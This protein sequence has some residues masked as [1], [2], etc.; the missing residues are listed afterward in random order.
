MIPRFQATEPNSSSLA[1]IT[2]PGRVPAGLLE[3]SQ[4]EYGQLESC[5]RP[6]KQAFEAAGRDIVKKGL[7]RAASALGLDDD[8]VKLLPAKLSAHSGELCRLDFILS[9]GEPVVVEANFGTA[10]GGS[11]DVQEL[12]RAHLGERAPAPNRARIQWACALV[13]AEGA[14][15]LYLPHWPWSHVLDPEGYFAESRACAAD[16]GVD[17]VVLSFGQLERE[18]RASTSPIHVLK[19]FATL[20]AV[21][22]GIDLRSLSYQDGRVRWIADEGAGLLSSKALMASREFIALLGPNVSTVART[23]IVAQGENPRFASVD[24]DY[25]LASRAASVLKPTSDHGG[26]GV[27]VGPGI[28]EDQW[29]VA[30]GAAYGSRHIRQ[31]FF[32][33]DEVHFESRVRSTGEHHQFEGPVS[34]GAYFVGDSMTGVLARVGTAALRRAPVNGSTGALITALVPRTQ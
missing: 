20:D 19:L 24:M 17:L 11:I 25:L 23:E 22:T 7:G 3:I 16:L 2:Q 31:Q 9:S 30:C 10:V 28:D 4:G 13:L 5:L 8:L 26:N 12:A 18:I 29:A 34:Y 1:D 21:R 33:T 32:A 6:V 27:V 15:R 14:D